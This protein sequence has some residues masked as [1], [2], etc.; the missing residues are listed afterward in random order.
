MTNTFQPAKA[1][2]YEEYSWRMAL[3]LEPSTASDLEI[4]LEGKGS[5]WQNVANR[6]N[7]PINTYQG[8]IKNHHSLPTL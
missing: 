3:E 5:W 6:F 1:A 7:I 8:I 4:G 2:L